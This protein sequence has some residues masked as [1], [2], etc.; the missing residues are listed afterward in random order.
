MEIQLQRDEIIRVSRQLSGDDVCAELLALSVV[1]FSHTPETRIA[2]DIGDSRGVLR[3]T[4]RGMRLTPDR[5][6]PLSH[7]E[8]ALTG[9]YP[10]VP[11]N[12]GVDLPLHELV[13]GERGSL[14]PSLANFAC[15]SYRFTS[16]RDG[17]VWSQH[18]IC[19]QPTGPATT[20]G[21][22]EETGTQ[23][24]FETVSLIDQAKVKLLVQALCE[25]IHGLF[26]SLRQV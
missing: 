9:H 26:I 15:S 19:G 23:I 10:C 5:G 7:A 8:R 4:G 1:E 24:E 17:E 2:L 14:G 11:S 3:D 25:R 13:W 21:Y 18:Y 22:T 16:M 6:D 12:S 20:R